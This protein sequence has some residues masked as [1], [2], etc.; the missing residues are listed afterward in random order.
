MFG[1]IL[2]WATPEMLACALNP[3]GANE[4]PQQIS[5]ADAGGKRQK[6]QRIKRQ[7]LLRI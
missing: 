2:D 7:N 3:D 1:D 6:Y 5:V 4:V